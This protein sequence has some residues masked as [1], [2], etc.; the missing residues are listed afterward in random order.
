MRIQL[1]RETNKRANN[2]AQ[3]T[4]PVII[5]ITKVFTE[6]WAASLCACSSEMELVSATSILDVVVPFKLYNRKCVSTHFL[7]LQPLS[8]QATK[9]DQ[10]ES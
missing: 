5:E 6:L 7:V 4:R 3:K 1:N 2:E 9:G 8:K 10:L